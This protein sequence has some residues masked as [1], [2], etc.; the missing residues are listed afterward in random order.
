V[1][2]AL[3]PEAPTLQVARDRQQTDTFKEL[4]KRRAGIEGTISQAAFAWGMQRTWY[5]E[6]NKT[7]RHH[8]VA[9][10]AINLQRCVDW[11]W[12]VPHWK[13]Y[14]SPVTLLEP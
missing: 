9:V 4:Y 11:L 6:I 3:S 12:E 5:L 2:D 14:Q 8:I 10:T 7:Y 1:R 13:V